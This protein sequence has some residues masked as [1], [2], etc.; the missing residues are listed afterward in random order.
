MLFR[1]NI[2]LSAGSVH[3]HHTLPTYCDTMPAILVACP[4][5]FVAHFPTLIESS[6]IFLSSV[7]PALYVLSTMLT[8]H[9]HSTAPT[10]YIPL[11]LHV[12]L[13]L[14]MT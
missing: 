12:P 13:P 14:P 10:V 1:S 5:T 11:T 4:P 3:T 9:P 7:P 2:N 8:H 6:C